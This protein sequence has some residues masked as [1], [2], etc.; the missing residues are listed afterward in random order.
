[1]KD[2]LF[3]LFLFLLLSLNL[4]LTGCEQGSFLTD[5]RDGE[6]YET[7]IV[8][9]QEWM[10]ENLRFDAAG[11]YL[12]VADNPDEKYGR[13]YDW[14]TVMN[15]DPSSAASPSGVQG[16]CPSGWHLPSDEEWSTLEI[17]LGM[18]ASM[19]NGTQWR[20]T[21]HG[22]QLKSTSGWNDDGSGSNSSGLNVFP[23]G[24]GWNSLGDVGDFAFFWTST[25]FEDDDGNTARAWFRFLHKEET[26]ASRA[27]YSKTAY[28]HSCRCVK[29]SSSE[30]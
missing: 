6:R 13:L 2:K 4:T 28:A 27:L 14:P 15:G 19:A 1:M 17:S 7:V 8:G 26:G 10:A 23:A 18:D 11:S 9:D 21:D 20:G 16:I 24:R 29:D 25:D 22:T 12:N 30:E 5:D 3:H